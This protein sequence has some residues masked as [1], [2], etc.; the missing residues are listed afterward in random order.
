MERLGNRVLY[1]DTDSIIYSVK[2]GEYNPPLGSYLGQLT[3]ELSC[4]ELGCSTEKLCRT[5]DSGICELWS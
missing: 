4:K 1:H 2:E 3:D 5:L